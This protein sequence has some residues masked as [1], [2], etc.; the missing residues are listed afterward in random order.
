MNQKKYHLIEAYD[1]HWVV[2]TEL[3]NKMKDKPTQEI[4]NTLKQL[5]IETER[6]G[7]NLGV[8]MEGGLM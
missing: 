8:M 7:K 1:K 6:T 2:N 4:Y 5:A 3:F